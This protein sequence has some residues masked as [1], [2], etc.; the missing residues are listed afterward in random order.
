MKVT[1]A[2]FDRLYAVGVRKFTGACNTL[3]TNKMYSLNNSPNKSPKKE[4]L[5][6]FALNTIEKDAGGNYILNEDSLTP[7][8]VL[9][10][11]SKLKEL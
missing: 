6:L 8:Q 4:M 2:E 9:A 1:N 5:F 10:I 3:L 11:F 7:D